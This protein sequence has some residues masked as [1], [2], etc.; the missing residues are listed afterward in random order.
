MMPVATITVVTYQISPVG[1]VEITN[2]TTVLVCSSV[3]GLRAELD[4]EGPVK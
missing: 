3:Y 4:K 1:I 2:V